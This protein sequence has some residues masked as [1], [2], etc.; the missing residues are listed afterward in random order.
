MNLN[1][2]IGSIISLLAS[3]LMLVKKKLLNDIAALYLIVIGLVWF[4][5]LARGRQLSSVLNAFN[6]YAS[7]AGGR[8]IAQIVLSV[9][10][11]RLILA[12][13]AAERVSMVNAAA[14]STARGT[15]CGTVCAGSLQRGH[16][17]V[18]KK[19]EQPD[20]ACYPA[21]RQLLGLQ[22]NCE[23]R[24]RRRLSAVSTRLWAPETG[25]LRREA[26]LANERHAH[27][28]CTN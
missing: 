19:A 11:S 10:A 17:A 8:V 4:A 5:W 28:R 1:V 20:P 22:S 26:V 14:R 16:R 2:S 9:R 25:S 6:R 15:A 27:K 24:H 23:E 3:A 18:H 21:H 12:T 7:I 13:T